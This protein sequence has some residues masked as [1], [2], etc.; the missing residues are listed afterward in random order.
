MQ[1][2]SR[3]QKSEKTCLSINN[4]MNSYYCSE[5]KQQIPEEKM[6]EYRKRRS[7]LVCDQCKKNKKKEYDNTRYSDNSTEIK[8][9]I[10]EYAANNKELIREN[11]RK[12]RAK[13]HEEIREY[14]EKYRE[15]YKPIRNAREKERIAT[16]PIYALKKRLRNNILA[17][18]KQSGHK[19]QCST[20]EMLGCSFE[21]FKTY[22]ESKFTEG[23]TWE[24]FC[25]SGKIHIDHIIPVDFFDLSN[26]EE[27][28]KCFHYTNLQPLW[29]LDNLKKS[30]K[31][32]T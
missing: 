27:V 7:R 17:Y 25:T 16:D 22:F 11:K 14:F 10:K 20:S 6:T 30:N 31:L 28:K 1:M 19:K 4:R 9:R 32:P 3:Q 26:V 8:Y 29:K 18:V 21:E 23:M 13:H 24:I 15:T 2:L 5:C 12:Y